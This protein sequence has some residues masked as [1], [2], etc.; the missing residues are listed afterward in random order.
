MARKSRHF[1]NK[2]RETTSLTPLAWES[3]DWLAFTEETK[4]LEAGRKITRPRQ[5]VRIPRNRQAEEAPVQRE[6]RELQEVQG[7]LEPGLQ[8]VFSAKE[9][10]RLHK[11]ERRPDAVLDLHGMTADAAFT[12]LQVFI[13][14]AAIQQKR[15]LL[16]ITG[17][18]KD[19][20][21]VLKQSL[22]Q[23]LNAPVLRP[24]VQAYAPEA[25]SGG[26]FYVMLRKQGN[27]RPT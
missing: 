3:S 7:F 10:R 24:Q 4:K 9:L 15:L 13:Q 19:G 12:S 14:R 20:K 22:P 5:P 26:A 6:T 23:W 1:P 27:N 17:K 25:G 2:G 16:V 18:G 11:G 21:G 8:G